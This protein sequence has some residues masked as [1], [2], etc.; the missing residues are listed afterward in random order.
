MATADYCNIER[1]FY[2]LS[3]DW[4]LEHE[5]SYESER[6]SGVYSAALTI[7]LMLLQRLCR[8]PLE[9]VISELNGNSGVSL[10]VELNSNSK[11]LKGGSVSRNSGGFSRARER[12]SADQIS[13]LVEVCAAKLQKSTRSDDSIFLLDGSCFS[14][15]YTE[16]N[17]K[18][19][20]RHS[21]GTGK[22]HYPQVRLVTA[23]RLSNGLALKPIFGEMTR[24]E[25]SLAWEYLPSLPAGSVILGDRNFGVFSVAFRADSLGHKVIFR[26]KE[27]NFNRALGKKV[28]S[29]C[30]I[31]ATWHPSK[32]ELKTTPAIPVDASIKGRFIR[33]TITKDGFPPMVLYFFTTTTLRA[34]NVAALYLKRQRIETHISQ[35]KQ[36]LKLEFISAKTPA[37]IEK[38]IYIAFL[39]FNLV[40]AI[41][42]AVAKNIKIPF[43]RI[44]FTSARRIIE[45]YASNLQ[46]AATPKEIE[47]IISTIEIGMYQTK[48]PNRSRK[49]SYPRVAKRNKSKYPI[50]SVVPE[51]SNNSEN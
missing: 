35:L 12:L 28:G 44:S 36:T 26:M 31:S 34:E 21:A 45:I 15:A 5:I 43:E 7:W 49:R 40:S 51:N 2:D 22:L 16:A 47:K 46:R 37:M 11:K 17:G 50:R 13:D 3:R 24:S 4:F 38:E 1:L 41:N 23:H 8:L 6:R 20:P 32:S 9:G 25:Q 10:F 27:D 18:K 42:S 14:T 30:N 39:T 29:D 48:L 33:R 19:F